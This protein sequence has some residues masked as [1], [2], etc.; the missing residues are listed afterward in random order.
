VVAGTNGKGSVTAMIERGLR[1]AGRR[2]GRYTSPHLIHIEERFAVDGAPITAGT[3][4]STAGRI[5]AAAERLP[6]PPSFFEATTALALEAFRDAGVEIAV[7]EVGLGGRL[8]ATNVV[9]P[10]AVVVTAVDYDHQEYLG[11][12][13]EQIAN[14]KAGVIKPGSLVVVADNPDVVHDVVRR[15]CEDVGAT[16]VR[17]MAGVVARAGMRAGLM[18]IELETPHRQY[19]PLTLALRGRHQV[20]N[21]MAAV[22]LLEEL[23][24]RTGGAMPPS[25]VRAALE[26]VVWPG[27]LEPAA[28]RGHDVLVDGA[29]NPAG[30]RALES[31]L[32]EAYGRRLPMVV[33]LMRD[34]D[35][36]GVLGALAPAA[37]HFI[38]T[39]PA[40]PRAASPSDLVAVATR[41]APGIPAE[42]IGRPV[43]ALG[44]AVQYGAPA[45]VAGSLYLAGEIRAEWT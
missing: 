30:A 43:D 24:G 26:D 39:A 32:A 5:R 45:V 44:R 3:F 27:R 2:T 15:R 28:W 13:L 31:Y 21:A 1:A 19:G 34:K 37:S 10:V 38:C 7:L 4:E 40:T 35:I 16:L 11:D 9:E 6:S 36:E 22:R 14:E 33:G 23:P 8:D 25:A 12:T 17:A 41:I 29:H 42:A 20:A 18:E